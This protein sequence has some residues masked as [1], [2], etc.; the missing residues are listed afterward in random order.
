M[1]N[2]FLGVGTYHMGD[3][4]FQNLVQFAN[5]HLFQS[6]QLHLV[7]S[8]DFLFDVLVFGFRLSVFNQSGHG[9]RADN[10][11]T[12][13]WRRLEGSILHIAGLVTEDGTEQLLL[14][15]R[16]G[17]TLRRDFTD[18]DVTLFH[19]R[20]HTNQ[21]VFVQVLGR[22]GRN[23]RNVVGQHLLTAFRVADLQGE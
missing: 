20:T 23:V 9:L 2:R 1:H 3:F 18:Q 21:T 8:F 10:H 22:L 6:I 13:G 19:F 17:F 15:S 5:Q 4:A 11:A 7:F 14:R 12:H 16:I